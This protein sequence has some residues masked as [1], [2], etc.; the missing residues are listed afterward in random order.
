MMKPFS[1]NLFRMFP[2]WKQGD[3]EDD[4][5]NKA[6]ET[7]VKKLK[8]SD[9]EGYRLLE[10]IL[11]SKS[12]DTR[13][14]VIPRPNDGRIQVNHK[15]SLPHVMYCRIFRWPDLLSQHELKPVPTCSYPA[16]KTCQ[17]PADKQEDEKVCV[18]PYHYVRVG[19]PQYPPVV[20]PRGNNDFASASPPMQSPMSPSSAY[21]HQQGSPNYF[22]QS[23][24][25]AHNQSQLIQPAHEASNYQLPLNDPFGFSN[26]S[27]QHSQHQIASPN[28]MNF[29]HSSPMSDASYYNY[30]TNG[31][32]PMINALDSSRGPQTFES[33]SPPPSYTSR[34]DQHSPDAITPMDAAD[35]TQS[36]TRTTCGFRDAREDWCRIQYSELTQKVGEPFKSSSPVVWVDGFTNPSTHN[37]SR[38]SLGALSNINRN[39]TV[40]QVRCAIGKGI[41]L[42]HLDGQVFVKNL[43]DRS[44]FFHSKN[45][46]VE[47][48]LNQHAVVKIEPQRRQKIFEPRVFESLV[49]A[50]ISSDKGD[51]YERLYSLTDHCIIK[52]SFVKGWGSTYQ[53]Q[54][55]TS[56]PC[57]IEICLLKPYELIDRY[58]QHVRP[59][60]MNITSTS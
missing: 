54:D 42:E 30:P 3:E 31:N 9:P 47:N 26:G 22:Q 29:G 17:Y 27:Q 51:S 53:R 50:A 44:I 40:E 46:N 33:Q 13:C 7:L 35:E 4:W 16:K 43:L 49:Q 12:K 41:C 60:S 45:C 2:N 59:S 15:K 38:F 28:S 56:T 24:N 52:M 19:H 5:R 18:N 20:A 14:L 11:I 57:W 48:Q 55:V 37:Q 25:A 39:Y 32:G 10:S 36:T 8:K 58:I 6:I 23:A 34:A 21:S 1:N